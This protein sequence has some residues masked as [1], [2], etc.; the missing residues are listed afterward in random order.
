MCSELT[1]L[2]KVFLGIY[3]FI[4][5]VLMFINIENAI[6]IPVVLLPPVSVC[7]YQHL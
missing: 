1:L 5:F 6:V 2:S 7:L 4:L 3:A